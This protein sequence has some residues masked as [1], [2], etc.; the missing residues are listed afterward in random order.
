MQGIDVSVLP[1]KSRLTR[2]LQDYLINTIS[3]GIDLLGPAYSNYFAIFWVTLIL[4]TN[5]YGRSISMRLER[6]T[7]VAD[8][9]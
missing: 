5:G 1:F 8:D 6:Q 3:I 2:E 7:S 4:L 9:L